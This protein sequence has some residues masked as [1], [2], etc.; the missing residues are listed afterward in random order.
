MQV[1]VAKKELA[2]TITRAAQGLAN[3]PYQAV[4]AGMLLHVCPADT[5]NP[6]IEGVL[7]L[8]CSDG[9]TTFQASAGC[10]TDSDWSCLI[11]GR[12]VAEIAKYFPARC[13]NIT[14]AYRPGD[15]LVDI[16]AG[17]SVFTLTASDGDDYPAS[18]QPPFG[19]ASASA[20]DFREAVS[21]VAP[22]VADRHMNP[23][24]TG[25]LFQVNEGILSIVAT[26]SYCMAH[27]PVELTLIGDP[28]P[29]IVVPV[30]AVE[31][32]SRLATGDITLGWDDRMVIMETPDLIV[33]S[34]LIGEGTFPTGWAGI[35][36]HDGGWTTI[37]TAELA[38][39]VR[40]AALIAPQ[41]P[42]D[43]IVLD[44]DGNDLTVSSQGLGECAEYVPTDYQ[45]DPV[46]FVFGAK[47]LLAGLSGCGEQVRLA[48]T[49]AGRRVLLESGALRFIMQ[50]RKD[51]DGE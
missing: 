48:F 38:R 39:A 25:L 32:F 4:Y 33:M 17:R 49:T 46:R 22:A 15:G 44:F 9:F 1:T 41:S 13:E 11:P 36:A 42:A 16:T 2:D 12:M 28:E 27:A 14:I 43:R 31:R 20:A 35:L 19:F 23:A 18:Y 7:T 30:S 24:L 10:G 8:T 6:D 47:M 45:G 34:R 29:R 37:E 50:P 51:T 26:D 3:R 40:V 21:K 5:E